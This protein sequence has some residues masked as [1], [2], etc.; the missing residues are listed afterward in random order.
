[1]SQE[2]PVDP[3]HESNRLSTIKAYQKAKK[4]LSEINLSGALLR[5]LTGVDGKKLYVCHWDAVRV[6]P[7]ALDACLAAYRV[8]EDQVPGMDQDEAYARWLDRNGYV[9]FSLGYSEEE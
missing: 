7:E 1:M 5:S 3:S 4:A 9:V 2:L 8:T 6:T